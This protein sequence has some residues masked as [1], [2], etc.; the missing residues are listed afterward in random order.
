MQASANYMQAALCKSISQ[1]HA[2]SIAANQLQPLAKHVQGA[3]ASQSQAIKRQ[4]QA[5]ASSSAARQ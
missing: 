2:I 3:A 1:S 4:Q 5:H